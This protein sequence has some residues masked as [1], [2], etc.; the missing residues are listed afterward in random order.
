M[1][2]MNWRMVAVCVALVAVALL[3]QAPADRAADASAATR[4]EELARSQ[5]R[6]GDYAGALIAYKRF[7]EENDL[8]LLQ[9]AA[10]AR[11]RLGRNMVSGAAVLLALIGL[12]VYRRR[13]E[14]E[15]T[16]ERVSVTDPL[17]GLKNRRY[18]VHTI[19]ADIVA[20]QR[21]R[22]SVPDG[23]RA[24][25]SDLVLLLVDVDRFKSV[26]DEFSHKAGDAVLMQVA[27]ALRESCRGSD[28]IA[29]WGG[30]EFLVLSRFTDRRTGSVI[31]E[32]I[33]SA[34]ERRAF[35][36]GDDSLIHRT[37]SVGFAS[38]PFSLTH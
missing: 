9:R 31:A 27:D 2:P 8:I 35:D 12:G 37:C 25:D 34:I 15:R 7:K 11:W 22:R 14:A 28:A 4:W 16:A 13:I 5:E 1:T 21:K 18:I 24:T 19:G 36:V 29:R 17:T 30:D 32:R 38:Y 33:R 10:A 6:A 23:V 20:A 3:V 26:N